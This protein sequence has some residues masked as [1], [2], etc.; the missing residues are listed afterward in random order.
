MVFVG[1]EEPLSLG[2][3][4]YLE[5]RGV[6]VFGPNQ[7]AAQLEA[8]K[9]FSKQF[10]TRHDIPTG[11]A[12]E[13]ADTQSFHTH[14]SRLCAGASE[15]KTLVIKKSGLAAG[16]GVLVTDDVEE[17]LRFGDQILEDDSLL[18]EEFLD[19][20]EVS[21]FAA[22]D[23]RTA[24]I[25]P[26][27]AD[28]KKA[29]DQD[30]GP[31]TGGMGSIAP[32]P[33]VTDG[34]ME[35]IRRFIVEPTFQGFER[36]GIQYRGMLYFGII[37]TTEGPKVL[38]Y[39]VR[40][41]DPETQVLLPVIDVDLG[42][43]MASTLDASLTPDIVPVAG[44]QAVGVV[45]AAEGYPDSYR[46]GIPV[47]ALPETAEDESIVFHASTVTQSDGTVVTGGGR[48][49]TAVGLGADLQEAAAHSYR[50]A[51]QIQ[52]EGCWYRS[53]IGAVT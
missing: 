31:N 13:F 3:A 20:D 9:C 11:A 10:M 25:F 49:F 39:N 51:K 22:Y 24:A 5:S 35:K 2:I 16:K 47:T 6:R 43:I 29:Y 18:V 40:F 30:S 26:P 8:S 7:Q 38:E 23:G 1:P 42:A 37:M 4:D 50:C 45:V 21:V 32:V 33:S 27:C 12:A 46:K 14:V 28:Y 36:E 44:R 48:C 17:A 53:D 41:G 52:F 19:G 34:D 15:G